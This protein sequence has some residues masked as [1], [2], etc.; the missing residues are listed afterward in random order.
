MA[1]A[2]IALLPLSFVACLSNKVDR[3]TVDGVVGIGLTVPDM[4]K[5]CQLGAS[6]AHVLPAPVR[7]TP[8]KAMVIT[9]VTS[10]ACE[11]ADAWEAELAAAR[12]LV[13]LEGASRTAA[14]KDARILEERHHALAAQ[15]F[16]RSYQALNEAFGPVGEGCPRIGEDDEIVYLLGLYAGVN[17]LLHDKAAGNVV[18]VPADV[19][20]QVSR[21]A[22]CLDDARWWSVPS[23]LTAACQATI[24]GS[25]PEGVDP[26]VELTAAAA[27]GE[28]E[29]VRLARAL[30]VLIASNAGRDEHADTAITAHA[31]SLLAHEPDPNGRLLDEYARLVSLHVA[32]LRWTAAE[33]H[34]APALGVPPAPEDP[35]AAGADPFADDPFGDPF[36]EPAPESVPEPAP[37]EETP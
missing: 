6:F 22:T 34:R 5:A 9:E 8:H 19:V 37:P 23:A 1:A 14:V 35:E 10:A 24:P 30:E 21:G 3:L 15:R 26:W 31:A 2:V 27:A 25:A 13:S 12:A 28:A 7:R 29:G 16:W 32:D 18:G 17:A 33:G 36:A 20:A 11:E 4:D